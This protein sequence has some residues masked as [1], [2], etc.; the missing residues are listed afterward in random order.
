M[1][2]QKYKKKKKGCKEDRARLFSVVPGVRTRG[3]GHRLEH[4]MLPQSTRSTSV[5]CR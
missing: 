4:R 2:V 5:L 1:N 3:S